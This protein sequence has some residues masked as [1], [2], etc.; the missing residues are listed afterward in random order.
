MHSETR[1]RELIDKLYNRG[2]CISYHRMLALST[3]IGNTMCSQFQRYNIV[4]PSILK[5]NLF[6]TNAIDKVDRDPSSR[7]AKD[8]FHGTLIYLST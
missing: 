2:L 6:R 1:I 8:A 5:R 3:N 4:C 7:S